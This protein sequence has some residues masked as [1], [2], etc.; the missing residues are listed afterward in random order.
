VIF[1]GPTIEKHWANCV[2]YGVFHFDPHPPAKKISQ[3]KSWT[4]LRYTQSLAASSHSIFQ[5]LNFHYHLYTPNLPI[6]LT[7]GISFSPSPLDFGAPYHWQT[8]QLPFHG[9]NDSTIFN[10]MMNHGMFMDFL[11]VPL[12]TLFLEAKPQVPFACACL[13]LMNRPMRSPAVYLWVKWFNSDISIVYIYNIH[14]NL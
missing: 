14:Y 7:I 3:R 9:W 5:P 12:G 8:I 6:K 2:G 11:E 4:H 1:L 13:S 10:M